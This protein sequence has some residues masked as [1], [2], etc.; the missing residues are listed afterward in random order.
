[1]LLTAP[2]IAL[3]LATSPAASEGVRYQPRGLGLFALTSEP[4]DPGGWPFSVGV[5]VDGNWGLR[6][7]PGATATGYVQLGRPLLVARLAFRS[8]AAEASFGDAVTTF[9]LSA[10]YT[11]VSSERFVAHALLGLHVLGYRDLTSV[12]PGAGLSTAIRLGGPVSLHLQGWVTPIPF[13]R[14]GGEAALG[15]VL[16]ISP[17]S[18]LDFG[19]RAGWRVEAVL[20]DDPRSAER[21]RGLSQ[22]AFVG[23][24]LVY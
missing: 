5:G 18:E 23:A 10:G 7:G 8:V 11:L 4:D 20:D 17:T 3:A 1:M 14:V 12:G 19:V 6:T 22:G 9:E 13:T 2:L 15:W 21:Y 16:G 24:A